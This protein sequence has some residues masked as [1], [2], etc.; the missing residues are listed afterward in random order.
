LK[1]GVTNEVEIFRDDY[2]YMW[3][4]MQLFTYSG[5]KLALANGI[6]FL[7]ISVEAGNPVFFSLF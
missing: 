2:H 5:S 4:F 7:Q 3:D 6:E 1:V